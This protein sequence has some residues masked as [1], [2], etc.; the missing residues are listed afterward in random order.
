[1]NTVRV[2]IY[3]MAVVLL[4]TGLAIATNPTTGQIAGAT[5]TDTVFNAWQEMVTLP[6]DAK[7]INIVGSV[8]DNGGA[9]T[10]AQVEFATGIVGQEV[11]LQPVNLKIPAN[12]SASFSF[13]VPGTIAAGTRISYHS[14]VGALT[15]GSLRFGFS[16]FH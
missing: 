11:L 5:G 7:T 16:A 8:S 15:A 13:S 1:M 4:I 6:A 14:R 9:A 12:G 10:I 3:T 2:P